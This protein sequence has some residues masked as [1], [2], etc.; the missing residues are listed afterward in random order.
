MN[1][2]I[3][4]SCSIHIRNIRVHGD[5]SPVSGHWKQVWP[6]LIQ[7]W[8]CAC[9]S[10]SPLQIELQMLRMKWQR[11][12]GN[13]WLVTVFFWRR[14]LGFQLIWQWRQTISWIIAELITPWH[15]WCGIVMI[16]I[17]HQTCHTHKWDL[18]KISVI[19]QRHEWD[20]ME[21]VICFSWDTFL[22]LCNK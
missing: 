15:T 17:I 16:K 21:S 1:E 4:E 5:R 2:L 20:L 22:I 12:E 3:I 11:K 10:C 18:L 7:F 19:S 13:E 8:P 9:S 6:G 14:R